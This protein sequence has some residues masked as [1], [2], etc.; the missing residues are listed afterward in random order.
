MPDKIGAIMNICFINTFH[1]AGESFFIA[2][3]PI[4]PLLSHRDLETVLLHTT[5]FRKIKIN[6]MCRLIFFWKLYAPAQYASEIV[7]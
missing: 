3:S 6:P 5:V 1:L 4:I 7:I 2:E